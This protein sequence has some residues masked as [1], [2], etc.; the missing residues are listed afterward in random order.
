MF[1]EDR[2]EESREESRE[3]SEGDGPEAKLTR[4]RKVLD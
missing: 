4:R 2:S 3:E 1:S